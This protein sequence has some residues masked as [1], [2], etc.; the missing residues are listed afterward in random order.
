MGC[1]WHRVDMVSYAVAGYLQHYIS[2]GLILQL[3]AIEIIYFNVWIY[4]YI[5]FAT[6]QGILLIPTLASNHV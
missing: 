1:Y 5:Y 2:R 3:V 6:C 4:K